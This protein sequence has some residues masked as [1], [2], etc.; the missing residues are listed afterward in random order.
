MKGF[1]IYKRFN[2]ISISK[3]LLLSY[4]LVVLLPVLLIG[5]ILTYRMKEMVI[6]RSIN[7]ASVNVE[8]IYTRLNDVLKL[9]IDVSDRSQLDQNLEN[10]LLKK[11]NSTWEVVDAYFQ[12]REFNNYITYFNREIN[13]IKL[14]SF[15]ETMLDGGPLIKVTSAISNL[16]WFQQAVKE[17]GKINFHYIYDQEA[18]E[19]R[20][21]L[22]RMIRGIGTTQKPLGIIVISLK[23]DYLN[24]IFKNEPYETLMVSDTGKIIAAKNTG[25]AGNQADTG[26]FSD[27]VET[28]SG[29]YDSSSGGHHS[30]VIIKSFLPMKSN[31]AFKIVSIVPVKQIEEQADETMQLGA[32][33]M[34]ASLLLA[35]GLILVFSNAI[36]KRVKNISRDMH[37]V[38]MGN[39]DF[40]PHIEGEDEIGQLSSDLGIMVKSIKDLVHEVYEVNLQKNRL[41]VRQREIKLKMLASQINPHFLFNALETIR[42]K[43]HCR[44]EEEIAEVVKLLGR[45]L[46]RNLE[47][48]SEMASLESEIDMVKSYLE[49]QKFRYGDRINYEITFEENVKDYKIMPL[50]IQPIVENAIVHGLESKNSMGMVKINLTREDGRLKII[51]EDNGGG[52]DAGQLNHVL[53]TLKE[54]EDMPG[55]RIGLKNVHQRIK[56]SCGEEYGLLIHSEKGLGTRIAIILPEEW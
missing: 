9:V 34:A 2:N 37:K 8:R 15:N 17:N 25:L 10:L 46:R 13:D 3:K 33:I 4:V 45:I 19:E 21:C 18:K 40:I 6:E 5:L 36:S 51:V 53:E 52:M 22:V 47:V 30:K 35:L 43:A 42:M 44:G 55:E 41:A 7:E 48:G 32:A 14:Y 11:Y 28:D 26:V 27:L 23:Q 1:H 56:L 49:V 20:L 16:Y 12:Y 29:V 50:L 39:F 54:A 38:A 24:S 31:N